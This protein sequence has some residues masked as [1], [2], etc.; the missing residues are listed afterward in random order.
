MS[1]HPIHHA[2]TPPNRRGHAIL[3]I[4]IACGFVETVA[5]A[6]RFL[7]RRK[8]K[9]RLQ[10]DDWFIFASLWP[11]YA[12]IITGGFSFLTR[13][14]MVVFLQMLFASMI[15][16]IFTVT[17]VRISI[18]LL[19]RRIFD[20]KPF[21]IITT[22]LIAACIAWGLSICAA[23]I[24]QCHTILDAFKPEVVA[25]LDG[26]CINLQAM[27]YGTLGTGFT[28]DLIILLLPFQQIWGLRL[29]RRRKIEL[30]AILGLGG[31]ACL[32]SIMRIVALG[33]LK[34][35]DLTYS[36][37]STYMWSQI[38]PSAAILC[39][40][41]VTY[42][43]LFRDLNLSSV[44]SRRSASKEESDVSRRFPTNVASDYGS[45]E[46][47]VEKQAGFGYS[48]VM[49]TTTTITGQ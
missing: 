31:L 19:Y 24:F 47:L 4:C 46:G 32:A 48:H 33:S 45:E 39:A 16:Y 36:G 30:M 6:L 5:V 10:I 1:D 11:N 40:C 25:A 42:R 12:M 14:Q 38:E 8:M 49:G 26:R 41:F 27:F 20:I 29:E 43:P 21:R 28:L 37:A 13:H 2:T 17:L 3:S 9:A 15:T 23:N 22:A 18:L 44:F 34:Q 35:T 7:A